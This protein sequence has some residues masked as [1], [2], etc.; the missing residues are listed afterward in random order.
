MP[1]Q[2]KNKLVFN[3]YAARWFS[4]FVVYLDLESLITPVSTVKDKPEIFSTSIIEQ[5]QPCSYCIMVIERNNPTPIHFDTYTGPD[6]ME[7]LLAKLEKLAR[8][9]YN[10]KRKVP[11]FNGVAPSKKAYNCCWICNNEFVNDAEKVLDHCHFTGIFIGYAHNECNLKRRT[12]NFTPIV[13]HNM[14]DYDMH[15]IVK[16]LHSA[17]QDTK[18]N[19]IPTNDEKFI[20]LNF[21]VHIETKKR[22][23]IEVTV[24]EY[25]RF[26]DSFQFMP[27]SL[28]KLIQTLPADKFTILDNFYRGYSADQRK[29]LRKREVFPTHM[30]IRL[31]SYL[32]HHC[33]TF[34]TGKTVSEIIKLISFKNNLNNSE[35]RSES[36][37]VSISKTFSSSI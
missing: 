30:L 25:L 19:V 10:Q 31:K 23:T 14:M 9:F 6:C 3:N 17:S 7:R 15:H 36:S 29:L 21:G 20:A 34:R 33:L 32:K 35:N 8:F 16:A 28:D 4:P 13:A 1:E 37:T 27:G 18:I 22:K 26:I 5:H 24:Y 2:G 12:I 11:I